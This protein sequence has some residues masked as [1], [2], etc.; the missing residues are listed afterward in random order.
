MEERFW[1]AKRSCSNELAHVRGVWKK[2]YLFQ[3][4]Q[5]VEARMWNFSLAVQKLYGRG[6]R[7]L[8]R[9]RSRDDLPGSERGFLFN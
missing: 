5:W 6:R 8:S 1:L 4:E 2:V 7:G 3:S 9:E